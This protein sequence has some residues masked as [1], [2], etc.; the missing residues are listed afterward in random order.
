MGGIEKGFCSLWPFMIFLHQSRC[1]INTATWQK[2]N[3]NPYKQLNL[4]T[5]AHKQV[6]EKSKMN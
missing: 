2:L 6:F 1:L 4:P 5:T 3:R